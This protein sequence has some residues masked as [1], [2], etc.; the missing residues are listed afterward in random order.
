MFW[1]NIYIVIERYIVGGLKS[2]LGYSLLVAILC[3]EP[4]TV[5]DKSV[6]NS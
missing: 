1:L 5:L 3:K 6:N 2:R 4:S